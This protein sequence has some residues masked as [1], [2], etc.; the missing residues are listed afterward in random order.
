MKRRWR[1]LGTGK[2]GRINK[3]FRERVAPDGSVERQCNQC[4]QWRPLEEFPVNSTEPRGRR[5]ICGPCWRPAHAAYE[6]TRRAT[7]KAREA[8]RAA[9]MRSSL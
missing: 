1:Q 9:A 6:R 4:D 2:T 3:G 8:R 5:P 7:R